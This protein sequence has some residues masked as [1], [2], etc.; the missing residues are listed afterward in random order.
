MAELAAPI[1]VMGRRLRSRWRFIA[2]PA[3]LVLI[4]ASI[5]VTIFY[6]ES[7]RADRQ[8]QQAVADA[9]RLDP[10]WRLNDILAHRAKVVD[11]VNSA[12]RVRAIAE[13]LP[14]GWPGI[15]SY[16]PS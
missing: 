10:G 9:D 12:H 3:A 4:L 8:Y 6:T 13:K 7:W 1:R 14:G 16:D 5:A 11:D 2:V 15:I